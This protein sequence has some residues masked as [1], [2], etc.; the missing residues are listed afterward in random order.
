MEG[1]SELSRIVRYIVGVRFSG[2][3]VKRGSTVYRACEG[4]TSKTASPKFNSSV[5]RIFTKIHSNMHS[6]IYQKLPQSQYSSACFVSSWKASIF[7]FSDRKTSQ[8]PKG[9]WSG[10]VE[11]LHPHQ[12]PTIIVEVL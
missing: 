2:V 8:W 10:Y 3:S 6:I 5:N 12:P 9:N 7:T 4:H 11:Q 1:Q